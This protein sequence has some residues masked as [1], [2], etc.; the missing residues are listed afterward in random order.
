MPN[1]LGETPV[2]AR[3][4]G[5]IQR[6]AMVPVGSN[7]AGQVE[8]Q[9]FAYPGASVSDAKWSIRKFAYNSDNVTTSV[10]Y[11][12]GSDNFDKIWDNR[13]DYTYS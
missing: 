7:G 6:F 1:F 10:L 11:A 5:L 2:Y 12:G 4:V 8:Y 3:E 9:G 13:E